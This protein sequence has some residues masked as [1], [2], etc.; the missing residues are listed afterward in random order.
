MPILNTCIHLLHY[1]TTSYSVQFGF[2]SRSQ[3]NHTLIVIA[4]H[5]NLSLNQCSYCR[6]VH[7]I[8]LQVKD[9]TQHSD[10]HGFTS[11]NKR[12]FNISLYFKIALSLHIH[13]SF[14]FR[15][16]TRVLQGRVL[17]QP[18]FSAI[19]QHQFLHFIPGYNSH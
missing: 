5:L 12:L 11:H 13:I 3:H 9:R 1:Q 6:T 19:G 15:K 2:L 16:L 10:L 7:L 8:T 18:Y 4:F 14:L 17:I